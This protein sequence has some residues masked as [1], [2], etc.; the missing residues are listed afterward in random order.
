MADHAKFSPS[1]SARWMTCAASYPLNRDVPRRTS[2]WAAEGTAAHTLADRAFTYRKPCAFW[3]GEQ[4]EA[5]GFVFTVDKDMAEYVQQYVDY[6]HQHVF[7]GDTLMPEQQV[8]FSEAIGV[9]DQFGT[10][11]NIVVKASGKHVDVFD[12]KYGMGVRVD[13]D[14]NT[15]GMTYAAAVLETFEP[16]FPDI[17]TITVHIHQPRLDHV[18]TFETTV[19]RIRQ[20][21][22]DMRAAAVRC[23]EAEAHYDVGGGDSIPA[24][25]YAPEDKACQWCDIKHGCVALQRKVS[26]AVYN[27]FQALDDPLP[28]VV[29]PPPPVPAGDRLGA[30]FGL[31]DP[32]E[33]WARAVRA[34]VERMVQAGMTVT[35]PDGLAMKLIEGKRGNRAWTDP[36]AVEGVLVGLL[37]PEKAYKPREIATP[38]A[39][40]KM[41]NK[42]AT[43]AQWE[44]LKPYIKQAPG[45]PKV[46]LGSNPAAPYQPSAD[47]S[48]FADLGEAE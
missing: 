6:V 16:V 21:S 45:K 25:Y 5:D 10:S 13:A 11:D 12:L 33:G 9:P 44:T 17:E 4:I 41:L 47:A 32:I 37:P 42:A 28:L 36:D 38:S 20:H 39:V 1:A 23:F 14:E 34:E 35:G 27:D 7:Y 2:K 22:A 24:E 43:K 46:V 29:A 40:D 48:E 30:M 8:G 18:T 26:E 19:E 15:Q 31:L 3:I